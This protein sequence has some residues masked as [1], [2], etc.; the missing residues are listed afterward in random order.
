ML[1]IAHVG[2]GDEEG[3][4]RAEREAVAE[5]GAER[6]LQH[7]QHGKPGERGD[8]RLRRR[9][10]QAREHRREQAE[11][12]APISA[13]S[14]PRDV[15]PL[16]LAGGRDDRV[17]RAGQAGRHRADAAPVSID[18]APQATVMALT[19]GLWPVALSTA[20]P[21][22]FCTTSTVIASGTTS[23]IIACQ[24]NAARRGSARP[25]RRSA[26]PWRRSCPSPRSPRRR[27]SAHRPPAAAG[28]TAA[29]MR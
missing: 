22:P 6:G 10:Q 14:M 7:A 19:G 15:L 8:E 2:H 5:G 9:Q 23:S 25:W 11:A 1:K 13:T 29:A 20:M 28:A 26:R 24:E 27:R 21:C 4:Q 12:Q 18:P 17:H 3:H 16:A